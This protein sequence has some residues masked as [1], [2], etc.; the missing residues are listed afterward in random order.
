MLLIDGAKYQEWIPSSEKEFEQIVNE[1]AL[2]IFG[3]NSI[4][5]DR[6]LKLQSLSGIGSIPDGYVIT[7]GGI[8]QWHIIEVEL[9]S[10]DLYKH[11]VPQVSRFVNSIRNPNTQK[12]IVDAIYHAIKG[13]QLLYL[14][15]GEVVQSREVYKFFADLISKPPEITIIIEEETLELKDALTDIAAHLK[16]N[17]V[18]FRTFTRENVGLEVHAHLFEPL[19]EVPPQKTVISEV[20]KEKITP[21]PKVEKRVT[22]KDL[23]NAGGMLSTSQIIYGYHQGK[24]YEARILHDGRIKM[25]HSGSEYNSLSMA[26][27]KGIVGHEVN[28]WKWWH[29]IGEDGKECR[30]DELRKELDELM[31]EYESNLPN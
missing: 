25:L 1:H 8:P 16:K 30:L 9:S 28:G 5:I 24:R 11:V 27:F 22:I 18:E 6:K 14:R 4:Y 20:T 31:K 7:F 2:E 3:E 29:T 19:Y 21:T 23:M 17:V 26:A 12:I 10:H 13:D 15:I